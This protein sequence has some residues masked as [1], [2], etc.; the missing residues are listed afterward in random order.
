MGCFGTIRQGSC[1]YAF[2]ITLYKFIPEARGVL[3]LA[4]KA[5][6]EIHSKSLFAALLVVIVAAMTFW[7]V[8]MRG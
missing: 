8:M 1:Q 6:G 3:K 4:L 7:W 2:R 5:E